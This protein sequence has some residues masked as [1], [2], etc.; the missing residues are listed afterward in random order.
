MRPWRTIE[1]A[2]ISTLAAESKRHYLPATSVIGD[3]RKCA[4]RD[5]PNAARSNGFCTAH[6]QRRRRGRTLNAPL[7]CGRRPTVCIHCGSSSHK[8]GWNLCKPCYAKRKRD[9]LKAALI[10]LMGNRCSVCRLS[11]PHCVF[12]FHHLGNKTEGMSRMLLNCSMQAV[13]KEAAKCVLMCA[14]CHR[15][16]TCKEEAPWL[17]STKQSQ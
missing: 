8:G 5:C 6:Y 16:E 2:L 15:Q 10:D 12:D 1:Q 3:A 9:V 4:T 11:F 14:N 17:I 7:L 13:A